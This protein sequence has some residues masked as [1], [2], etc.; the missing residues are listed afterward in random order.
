MTQAAKTG[1]LQRTNPLP[2]GHYWVDVFGLNIPKFDAWL[3][4]YGPFG[5]HTDATQHFESPDVA[6][7]RNWYLFTYTPAFEG[8]V[9]IWDTLFGFPTIADSSIKSSE[10]TVNRPDL[11]LDVTDELG[12]WI[13]HVEQQLAGSLG[14]MAVVVPYAIIG[15]GLYA[16]YALFKY[17]SISG[18]TVRK[19]RNWNKKKK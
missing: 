12:N 8:A 17:A 4:A 5:I 3:K 14:N 16:A 7:V 9:V 13:N 2:P 15:G 6:S 18:S 10:D 11:P 1:T 19:V